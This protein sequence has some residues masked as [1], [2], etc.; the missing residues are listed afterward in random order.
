MTRYFENHLIYLLHSLLVL[1]LG[2]SPYRCSDLR[3][4]FQRIVLFRSGHFSDYKGMI[5]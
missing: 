5:E 1:V 3:T 4:V 2:Q